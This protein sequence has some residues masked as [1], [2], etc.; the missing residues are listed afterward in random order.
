MSQEELAECFSLGEKIVDDIA[1]QGTNIIGFGEMGIG[2]TSSASLLMASLLNIPIEECVGRGTGLNDEQLMRK[3]E[4]LQRA[5]ARVD[6]KQDG[7]CA[8]REFGGFEIAQICA[9]MLAAFRHKMIILVDGFIASAAF[10]AA[11][12]VEPDIVRNAVFCHKSNE[13]GHQKMLEKIGVKPLLGMD[14][15]LGEGIGCALAYPLIQSAV[16][17]IN[18][19]ASFDDA[20][21]SKA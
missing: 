5:I 20:G 2:N 7:M 14:L 15:R 10:L 13:Q 19:M 4:I 11:R 1:V 21:V 3:I 18:E 16:A 8:L 17:F 6:V 12:T 9:G